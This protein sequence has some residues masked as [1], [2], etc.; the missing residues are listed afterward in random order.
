M[1]K[2][3]NIGMKLHHKYLSEIDVIEIDKNSIKADTKT[4]G[5]LEFPIYDIG[6]TIYTNKLHLNYRFE[7]PELYFK[8]LEEEKIKADLEKELLL[9]KESN[10]SLVSL[11][12]EQ[13]IQINE[14]SVGIKYDGTLNEFTI[15]KNHYLKHNVNGYFHQYYTGYQNPGNPDFLNVLKNTFNSIPYQILIDARNKVLDIITKDIANIMRVSNERN[16]LCMCVPRA[17]ALNEYSRLQLMFIEAVSLAAQNT[18]GLIDGTG[19]IVRH[20]NTRT[21]HLRNVP[22]EKNDGAMPYPGITQAT[23]NINRNKIKDKNI[24]LVD[25]IYTRNVNIDEDCI[26]ALFD[27]GAKNIIFYAIGYTR[28]L[29]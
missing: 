23:C 27:N 12:K 28:R 22:T 2:F 5:L 17:K 26:Q 25:D 16:Y 18:K 9:E 24:I 11:S 4:H 10:A 7:T 14:E 15:Y 3:I 8:F 19:Y 13:E 1:N 21:T 6:K 29:Q 20:K